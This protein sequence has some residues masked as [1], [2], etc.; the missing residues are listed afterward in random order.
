MW[1]PGRGPGSGRRCARL[2]GAERECDKCRRSPASAS[3]VVLFS[4]SEPPSLLLRRH[5]CTCNGKSDAAENVTPAASHPRV[6]AGEPPSRA[7]D[8]T[9]EA[10]GREAALAPSSPVAVAGPPRSSP[11]PRGSLPVPLPVP[12]LPTGGRK[13]VAGAAPCCTGRRP[14]RPPAPWAGSAACR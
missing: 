8:G 12:I 5:L 7:N 13:R 4:P 9:G 6:A 14:P 10:C 11:H 1:P 3:V 2:R